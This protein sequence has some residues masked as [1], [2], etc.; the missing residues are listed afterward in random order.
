MCFNWGE[1]VSWSI[2][3]LREGV[4]RILIRGCQYISIWEGMCIAY[5][6]L[7]GCAGKKCSNL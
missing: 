3:Y 1:G 7:E 2:F 4:G 6:N 5:F